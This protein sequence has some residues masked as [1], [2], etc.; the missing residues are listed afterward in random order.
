MNT[1]ET[2]CSSTWGVL[3]SLPHRKEL[4]HEDFEIS[5]DGKVRLKHE[6]FGRW[7]DAFKSIRNLV[8]KFHPWR[9]TA[10]NTGRSGDIRCSP[11]ERVGG[12][13]ASDWML[14]VPVH[15]SP[16][17]VGLRAV[18]RGDPVDMPR[19]TTSVGV[20]HELGLLAAWLCET[21]NSDE[22][23]ELWASFTHARLDLNDRF[24]RK[25]AD[26][27][28]SAQYVT[29]LRDHTLHIIRAFEC[30]L[31]TA[32]GAPDDTIP[33]VRVLS[34][35]PDAPLPA[36][37]NKECVLFL[38]VLAHFLRIRQSSFEQNRIHC[39]YPLPEQDLSIDDIRQNGLFG[40]IPHPVAK[41]LH[42]DLRTGMKPY[43]T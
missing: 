19:V 21:H 37:S 16:M 11:E 24:L 13:L 41:A 34:L 12:L 8:D 28:H 23:V 10:R 3:A 36:F 15:W 17:L 30:F 39:V 22:T 4:E 29:A 20:R 14:P 5:S 38:K 2:V 9:I 7:S 40:F 33:L 25:V 42:R 1:D 27:T 35:P 26:I 6:A 31:W 18:M 43:E 32:M